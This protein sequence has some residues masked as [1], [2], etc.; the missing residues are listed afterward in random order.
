MKARD[1]V[2]AIATGSVKVAGEAPGV[3]PEVLYPDGWLDR[4]KALETGDAEPR[5]WEA[6]EAAQTGTAGHGGRCR[7][8]ICDG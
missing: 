2:K 6:L 8:W 5:D 3:L 7:C 1:V 4:A